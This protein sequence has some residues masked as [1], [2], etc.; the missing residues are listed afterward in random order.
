[1]HYGIV[2]KVAIQHRAV[3]LLAC[4]L[5]AI[6]IAVCDR[7]LL[8]QI[9]L[10]VLYLFPLLTS[11]LLLPPWLVILLAG[12]ACWLKEQFGPSAWDD[13]AA[14]RLAISFVAFAG[15]GL[16]ITELVRRR[17]I[18][19]ASASQ[20]TEQ[21]GRRQEAE[22]DARALVDSSPAAI[23]T[24]GSDGLIDAANEAARRLLGLNGTSP[25]GQKITDYFPIFSNLFGA[26][27]STALVRA[28]VE[29]NGRRADGEMFFA[30]MW[31]SSY[32]TAAGRKLVAVVADASEQLRDREEAGLRQLLMNSKIIAG[33]VSHEIRN[34]AAAADVL[35]ENIGKAGNLA[36]NEDFAALGRLIQAMRRLSSSEVPAAADQALTG[37]DVNA[38][39]RQLKIILASSADSDVEIRWEIA[40]SLPRVRADQSGLLQVFLN[41]AQN[42]RRA[43]EAKQGGRISIVAYQLGG[44]VVVRFADN[45]TGI[46]APEV[47]FHPFQTGAASTGLGLYVSR[48]VIRTYGGELQYMRRAGEACFLIEL[49]AM[50]HLESLQSA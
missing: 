24:V 43:L 14:G 16:F 15:S 25:K 5:M 22:E 6:A 23:V 28:M 2:D 20:L 19:R 42:S 47:I 17:R 26:D 13:G 50:A 12:A 46:A 8:A 1:M 49:P 32:L 37:V 10:G 30:Q 3:T 31:L 35:H 44:S 39:L 21:I 36:N 38:L 41:L 4:L 34:L 9:S 18:E 33:A 29:G 40:D 45:G 7:Y 11:A 48:A 27:R